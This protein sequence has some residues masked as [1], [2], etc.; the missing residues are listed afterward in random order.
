MAPWKGGL[1][2][3]FL[4][5]GHFVDF[6]PRRD[7]LSQ[8]RF[9]QK[10]RGPDY[11]RGTMAKRTPQILQVSH[12]GRMGIWTLLGL[13]SVSLKYLETKEHGEGERSP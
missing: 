3:G 10:L 12:K 7:G 9:K 2:G 6:L 8:Q 1:A 4:G 5:K 11:I 13:R